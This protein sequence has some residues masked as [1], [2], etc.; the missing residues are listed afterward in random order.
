MA[1]LLVMIIGYSIATLPLDGGLQVDPTLSALV[2]EAD[3]GETFA[4][5]GVFKGTKLTA[6][7]LPD[8][9]TQVWN[10]TEG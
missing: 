8:H 6:A 4:T 9:L 2:I 3:N 10:G 7:D 5:R 1:I